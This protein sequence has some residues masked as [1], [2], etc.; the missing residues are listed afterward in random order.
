MAGGNCWLSDPKAY[1]GIQKPTYVNAYVH[2]TLQIYNM[3]VPLQFNNLI[4][5]C[6]LLFVLS[7]TTALNKFQ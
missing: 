7:T 5:I 1:I 6:V 3:Q 4:Q 2:I